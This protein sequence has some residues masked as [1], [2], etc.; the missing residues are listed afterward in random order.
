MGG[1]FVVDLIGKTPYAEL[2]PVT[3]G[4][5][6]LSEV[7]AGRLTSIAPYNG[8]EKKLSETLKAAHGM[9]APAPNRATGKAGQRA[10][11]FGN[12][13]ILLQGPAPD[14]KLARYAALSDQSDGWVVVRLDGEAATAVLARLTPIDLR[15]SQ[16]KRGHTARSELRH[17]MASITRLGPQSYQVMV[18]RGFANTLVHDLTTAMQGVAVRSV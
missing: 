2:L 13:M 12:R 18:F 16:F 3:I 5:T 8:Q 15:D 6:T 17:M 7:D 11:W 4:T 1:A 9:T 10:L 14:A